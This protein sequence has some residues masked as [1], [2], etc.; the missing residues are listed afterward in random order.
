MEI[1][2]S[3]DD[4][5]ELGKW[6]TLIDS[7]PIIFVRSA[8]NKALGQCFL[9]DKNILTIEAKLSNVE[10]K[11]VLEIG[12]GDGRLTSA[13][14]AQNPTK[15]IAVEMDHRYV[16]LMRERFIDEPRVTVIE[17]DILELEIEKVNPK[18]EGA[19]KD[20]RRIDVVIGNIPYYI[21]SDIIF[22][23]KDWPI[24]RAILMV[25][26]EFARKMVAKPG[27]DNYGRLSVTSQ[28]AFDVKFERLV[29]RHLFRPKPRVDSAIIR[30][31]PTGFHMDAMQENVIRSIFQHRNKTIRNALT[32]SKL[33]GPEDIAKLET[34]NGKIFAKRRGRTLSKDECL[35]IA[36]LFSE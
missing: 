14:L 15:I 11:N 30:L 2:G 5:S 4:F 25:Q 10:G 7:P 1:R 19:G 8:R 32:D 12:P 16:S 31:K 27:D 22:T 6:G 29:P 26:K 23:I 24:E 35:E 3:L 18:P 9:E 33:F 13:L 21:S 28:L 36:K 20:E 34:D 17:S